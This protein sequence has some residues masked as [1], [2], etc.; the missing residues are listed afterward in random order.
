MT[1]TKLNITL[2][3]ASTILVLL[4][5]ILISKEI[6]QNELRVIYIDKEVTVTETITEIEYIIKTEIDIIYV[7]VPYLIDGDYTYDQVYDI[8]DEI[9]EE[10]D[11]ESNND[12]YQVMYDTSIDELIIITYDLDGKIQNIQVITIDDL[13][14]SLE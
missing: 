14:E 2:Y 7:D 1:K 5:G 4:T 6:Y 3:I 13:I 8:V 11:F 10:W 9:L 12:R